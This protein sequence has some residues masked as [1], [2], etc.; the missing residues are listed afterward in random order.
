MKTAWLAVGLLVTGGCTAQALT[1]AASTAK[2]K[3]AMSDSIPIPSRRAPPTVAPV[4]H[5]GVRYEQDWE[6]QRH[7]GDQRGGYLVAVNPITGERLWML[8]VYVVPSHEASGV[9]GGGR[10]FRSM[11]LL[12]DRN[13]LEIESEVGGKYIVDLAKRTSTW[14]SGPDSVHK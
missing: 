14:I 10:H 5:G 6:S 11:R 7:G 12:A 1:A 9:T 2:E 3:T 13:A 4:V 8:K